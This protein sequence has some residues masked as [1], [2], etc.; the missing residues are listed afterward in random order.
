MQG[1]MDA[2]IVRRAQP[3]G[4]R[5][6]GLRRRRVSSSEVA[7]IHRGW[8][9]L[10]CCTKLE[11]KDVQKTLEIEDK[12]R[13]HIDSPSSQLPFAPIEISIRALLVKLHL[14]QRFHSQS[15]TVSE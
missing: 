7:S 3:Q 15:E 4:S 12:L 5:G 2:L 11:E 6:R 10:E 9:E 8:K 14:C 1:A 13:G